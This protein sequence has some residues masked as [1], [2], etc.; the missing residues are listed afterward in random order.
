MPVENDAHKVLT[1]RGYTWII[2]GED[3]TPTPTEI[4]SH[5]DRMKNELED[6][7]TIVSG[8]FIVIR[9]NDI[10]DVFVMLAE[11]E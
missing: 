8:R 1:D 4:R 2:D 9:T 3:R 10:Y 5:L 11:E 7:D 6:G